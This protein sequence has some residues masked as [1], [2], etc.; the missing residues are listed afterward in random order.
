MYHFHYKEGFIGKI[1]DHDICHLITIAVVMIKFFWVNPVNQKL[2]KLRDIIMVTQKSYENKILPWSSLAHWF[3]KFPTMV[4]Y[5][6]K[7]GASEQIWW[8]FST[9]MSHPKCT[10]N[11]VMPN[12]PEFTVSLPVCYFSFMYF[13]LHLL[14]DY[15]M[16]SCL[17]FVL[18][19]VSI[20]HSDTNS[21]ASPENGII[22]SDKVY[23][24]MLATDRAHFSRCNPYMDSPQSIGK[25]CSCSHS[26]IAAQSEIQIQS[27]IRGT[28]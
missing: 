4:C 18:V 26:R 5:Y 9:C 7:E 19:H 12:I 3:G 27:D 24:V 2:D 8:W 14:Q 23:E 15:V 25:S 20:I 28:N 10:S 21:F 17:V 13:Y 1:L 22:K 6:T 11:C 16:H